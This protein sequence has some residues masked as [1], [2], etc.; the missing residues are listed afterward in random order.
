MSSL[1]EISSPRAGSEVC[2]C[3]MN[4]RPSDITA[5][6]A[7][8][9]LHTPPPIELR[10]TP[11]SPLAQDTDRAKLVLRDATWAF[12]HP[13][14]LRCEHLIYM[15]QPLPKWTRVGHGRPITG[16]HMGSSYCTT[17]VFIDS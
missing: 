7:S 10:L 4:D 6:T 12:S 17:Y 5:N 2:S 3:K 13:M 11:T 14:P 8:R 1:W 9:G 15:T 16:M